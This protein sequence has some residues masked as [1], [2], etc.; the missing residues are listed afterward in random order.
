MAMGL[1]K[2]KEV[3]GL[4][5]VKKKD[6]GS[7]C[8]YFFPLLRRPLLGLVFFQDSFHS[9]CTIC[10]MQM[11]RGLGPRLR[12]CIWMNGFSSLSLLFVILSLDIGSMKL[13]FIF[14]L[15]EVLFLKGFKKK[16]SPK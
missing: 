12:V 13:D 7:I 16:C 11:V 15:L 6:M 1:I 3:F 9:L 14:E 2:A 8:V 4:H 10:F 5:Y